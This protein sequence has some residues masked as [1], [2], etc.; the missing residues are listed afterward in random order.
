MHLSCRQ[1]RIQRSW[2]MS[3]SRAVINQLD[4]VLINHSSYK[5]RE[6]KKN[7]TGSST[8]GCSGHE[9]TNVNSAGTSTTSAA[10]QESTMSSYEEYRKSMGLP[11]NLINKKWTHIWIFW[12]MDVD[13]LLFVD[14]CQ[15]IVVVT[16]YCMHLFDVMLCRFPWTLKQLSID[17]TFNVMTT[18]VGRRQCEWRSHGDET[19]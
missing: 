5:Q 13:W 6:K 17:D 11:C 16:S 7:S 3:Q 2:A 9:G 8:E 10:A 4:R 14:W 12:Y 15:D 1:W 19:T 18:S